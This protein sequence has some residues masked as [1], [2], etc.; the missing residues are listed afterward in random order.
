MKESA[1][2]GVR[3]GTGDTGSTG[4]ARRV[5]AKLPCALAAGVLAVVLAGAGAARAENECGPPEAGMPVVCSPSNYDADSDGNIVYHPSETHRGDFTIRLSDGLEVRYDR[6]DPD[7]DQLIF[8]TF[9]AP[10]YSAVRVETD[11]DHEGNVSLFSSANVTSNARGISVAHYGTSGATRTE[12]SGGSLS[13]ASDWPRAFAIQS[14]RLGTFDEIDAFSGHHDVVVRDVVIDLD[15]AASIGVIG[16]QYVAGYLNIA[17]QDTA[18]DIDARRGTGVWGSHS[19]TGDVGIEVRDVDIE[20]RG[21]GET[22]GI[23][24]MHLGAGDTDI[25]VR[26]AD[27]AVHGNEYSNGIAY[28]YWEEDK[29]GN[30]SVDAQDVD[31]EVHGER[32]L[33]GIFGIHRGAGEI[34]LDV[35]RAAIVMNGADSGGI[36]FVHDGD[37]G[38]GLDASD[39][40]IEVRGDR[41]VGIGGGRRYEGAGDIA[42]DVRDATVAVAGENAAGIRAFHTSGEGSIDVRVHGGTIAAQGPGSSGIVVGLAGGIFDDQAR[43]IKAPAG[44]EVEV[45]RS[46]PDAAL[47]TTGGNPAPIVTVNGLVRGGTGIGAGVRLYGGGRVEIGPRGSA[48][49]DSG[50]AVRAE[51][52]GAELHLGV[53]LD[54][55]R[56]V[57]AISGDIRNDDGRTTIVVNGT[58][59]HDGMTGATGLRAP[60]GARDVTLAMSGTIVGRAFSATDFLTPYAPRAGVYEALP[61][62]M[63]RLENRQAVGERLRRPGLPMW[64]RLSVGEGS[65]Q[66]DR[67]H[68]GAAYVTGRFEAEAG[69]EFT[70]SQE[71]NVT[72]WVSLRHVRGSADVSAPTGGGK[73]EATGF[74]PALGVSWKSTAGYYADGRFSLTHYET[75]LRA[76]G[77]GLLKAGADAQVRSLGVEVG[78]RFSLAD[79]LSLTPKAWLTHSDVSMDGFRD[80]VGS[81]VSLEKMGRSIAGLGIVAETMR[82]WDDGE[83]KLVLHGRLGVEGV[84][85]EAETVANVSGE[86]LGSQA[87]GTWGLLG[88]GAAY[89][90]GQWSLGAEVAA[91]GLGSDDN[92]YAASLR[93]VMLF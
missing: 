17:V 84:L 67:S 54:G 33:G 49:A 38:I 25:T 30:L 76:D 12:I 36:V 43:I 78:R 53:A 19:G 10:L 57:D 37:G 11:T 44:G 50:V 83:R 82:S 70:L 16:G 60:H 7:D 24:G 66:P 68:V 92:S 88:L 15:E 69:V 1:T 86:R 8:P 71:G 75:N 9:G 52:E 2:S 20:I 46:V 72:G 28:G 32:Y 81:R 89:R 22:D 73:I 29:A 5:S 63:L 80:T 74:G 35:R 48:G 61:G 13:I 85:G 93:L 39:V 64:A 4:V 91:S 41:S 18:I 59:L 58:T 45:D 21:P 79:H 87:A 56:P 3:P 23:Y 90:W 42:I 31:I 51:E 34:D 27:I 47:G 14:F 77:R 65:Y 40:E 6:H 55:R 26:G 62:F